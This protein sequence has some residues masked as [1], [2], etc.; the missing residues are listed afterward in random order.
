MDRVMLRSLAKLR[1]LGVSLQWWKMPHSTHTSAAGRVVFLRMLGDSS[2]TDSGV[3]S[4]HLTPGC[5]LQCEHN[6][7]CPGYLPPGALQAFLPR[8]QLSP[9]QRC[10]QPPGL[11]PTPT[12]ASTSAPSLLLNPVPQLSALLPAISSPQPLVSGFS[13]EPVEIWV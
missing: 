13:E 2:A 12:P 11:H 10:P 8:A 5:A 9:P 4:G 7:V 6:A 3:Q 1:N